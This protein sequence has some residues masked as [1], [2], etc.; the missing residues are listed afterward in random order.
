MDALKTAEQS[1]E[2]KVKELQSGHEK[3]LCDLK[4]EYEK[5]HSSDMSQ[6]NNSTELTERLQ[7]VQSDYSSELEKNKKLAAEVD[8][9]NALQNRLAE[10]DKSVQVSFYSSSTIL[11]Y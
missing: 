1:A 11:S 5:S 4:R 8:R 10:S 7:K 9:L 6:S 3:T 2:Q